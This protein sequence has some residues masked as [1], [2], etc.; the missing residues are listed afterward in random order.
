MDSETKNSRG[1]DRICQCRSRDGAATGRRMCPAGLGSRTPG[2]R[3]ERTLGHI[4]RNLTRCF[5]RIRTVL[6]FVTSET[7]LSKTSSLTL[8]SSFIVLYRLTLCY[9][10]QKDALSFARSPLTTHQHGIT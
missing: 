8:I 2:G 3:S 4:G 7:T 5:H 6:S 1:G 9:R 10:Q